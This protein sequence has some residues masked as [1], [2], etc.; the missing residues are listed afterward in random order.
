[1]V[2][3]KTLHELQFLL[4]QYLSSEN[5]LRKTIKEIKEIIKENNI[6]GITALT[7]EQAKKIKDLED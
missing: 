2:T 5:S 4:E 6:V 1:M 7:E 3:E